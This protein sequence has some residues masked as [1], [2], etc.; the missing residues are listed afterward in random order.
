MPSTI[1]QI[2]DFVTRTR[3]EDIATGNLDL[4]KQVVLDTL[5]C[6]LGAS[7]AGLVSHVTLLDASHWPQGANASIIGGGRTS[8]HRAI[9]LNGSMVRYL[10]FLDV[11]WAREICHPSENIPIAL[12][13]AEAYQ[14]NGKRLIE[15]IAIGYELQIRMADTFSFHAFGLHHVSAAGFIAPAMMGK[16]LQL[17]KDEMAHAIALGGVRHLTHEALLHGQLSMAKAIGYAF[18]ASD[19]INTTALA[20]QGFTGPLSVMDG[21]LQGQ[22][23]FDETFPLD[24]AQSL[25]KVSLKNYPIQFSLHAPVEASLALRSRH[26][27]KSVA[28]IDVHVTE[29]THQRT[30]DPAKFHPNSRETA[31][32][33]L[34]CCVAMAWLDNMLSTQQFQQKRWQD[35]DM[36]SLMRRIRV[37]TDPLMEAAHPDHKPARIVI[38]FED[39]TSDE[40]LVVQPVGTS[41]K[42]F[43]WQQVESK[44]RALAG[45]VLSASTLDKVIQHVQHLEELDDAGQL[46]RLL[47]TN[48]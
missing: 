18:A 4:I 13:C 19:C 21:F 11:Y 22:P 15:A 31:D 17:G 41:G 48:S 16:L 36:Q 35:T 39:G 30:A 20:R 29:L 44:F 43:T 10:D 2:S 40:E 25:P 33:S 38:N 14:Q 12:A 28:S 32:H 42:P 27:G 26:P 37:H 46:A 9:A 1:E 8:L 24:P 45:P 3:Y 34:P 5:G 47:Q 6:A 7:N 23:F